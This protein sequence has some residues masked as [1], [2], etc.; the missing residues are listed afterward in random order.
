M[1]MTHTFQEELVSAQAD[2]QDAL[3]WHRCEMD[4]G[5]K[6]IMPNAA[7]FIENRMARC[8][9]R[10]HMLCAEVGYNMYQPATHPDVPYKHPPQ[11][12]W[13]QR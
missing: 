10:L 2:L 4:Q 12:E 3:G 8:L 7:E 9:A 13:A 5:L 11:P 6:D 1:P